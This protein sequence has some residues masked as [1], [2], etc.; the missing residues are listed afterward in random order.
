V[1][2]V[3]VSGDQIVL[4]TPASPGRYIARAGSDCRRGEVVLKLGTRCGPTQAAVIA[5][6]G[7]R[8]K[9]FDRPRVAVLTTG[10]EIV[11]H[12]ATPRGTH[13]RDAS[14]PMLSAL[15]NGLGC[16]VYPKGPIEDDPEFLRA[17]IEK[18]FTDHDVVFI[19]GGMS[20]GKYDYV[21][22]ILRE[23]G[24]ELHVTKLRIKPGKPFVFG[25]RK[26]K[27]VFGLPGNPVSAFVCTLRLAS[28][29]IAR[30]CGE[31]VAERWIDAELESPL[32]ANGPREFYQP[33]ILVRTG[34][35]TVARPL[36]WRGSADVFTLAQADAL[37]VRPENDPQRPAGSRV[38]LLEV[39]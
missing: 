28:R 15:L 32:P 25:S 39:L 35:R 27:Y 20:M 12:G 2:D 3:T 22:R 16:F 38:Q 37:L 10:N 30:L 21:P 34:N 7:A 13:S 11:P 5:T 17:A 33:A 19:T 6:V 36:Q 23:I 18:A 9:Y 24:C 1:E 31:V 14:G 29:L 26:G 8:P 4:S